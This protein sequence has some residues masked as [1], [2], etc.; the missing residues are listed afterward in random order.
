MSSVRSFKRGNQYLDKVRKL[1]FSN[2]VK[3]SYYL[4]NTYSLDTLTTVSEVSFML[5]THVGKLLEFEEMTIEVVNGPDSLTSRNNNNAATEAMNSALDEMLEYLKS[6][7]RKYQKIFKILLIVLVILNV[8]VYPLIFISQV[9]KIRQ[10]RYEIL[11]TLTTLPKTVISGISASL[12]K[13]KDGKEG[14]DSDSE[15]NRQEESIIKLF[16]SISDGSSKSSIEVSIL[17]CIIFI[18]ILSCLGYYTSINCFM[19]SSK[20]LVFNSHHINYL[21][22][23]V[24]YLFAIIARLFK[25]GLATA[26]RRLA[27]SIVSIDHEIE[28]I[29]ETTPLLVSYFQL[30]RIGGPGN[31]EKPFPQMEQAMNTAS[32]L[33]KCKDDIAPPKTVMESVHCM[34]AGQQLYISTSLIK[35][36]FAQMTSDPPIY[37]DPRDISLQQLFQIGPVELYQSFFAKAGNQILPMIRDEI[38]KEESKQ[39]NFAVTFLI[40]TFLFSLII[41]VFAKNEEKVLLFTLRLFLRCPPSSIIGNQRVMDLLSGK[42]NNSNEE[43]HS[44]HVTFSNEVCNKIDTVIVVCEE[45][46]GKIVQ[47]NAAFE[48]MFS[49]KKNQMEGKN[50][51]E[52]FTE[53]RFKGEDLEKVFSQDANLIYTKSD[54]ELVYLYFN[55]TTA[56]G[57]RIY[58]GTNQTMNV[59][60]EKLIEDEKKK[61]DAMLNSI[62][63]PILVQRVQS[64]EKNISFSVQSVT[65]L[66]LDIVEF[67]PWC[68]SHDCHYVMRML[69]ILF[70]EFDAITNSHKTMTKIKCIGDCYMA[71]G[72]IFDEVNQPAVHAREVVEFGT[73]VIKKILEI[74][75]NENESLRI[76]V[77][78]NTGGPIV[79]GVIGTEKPTFEILGPAINIAHEMEHHGV[80]MK[81][82]ISRPVYELIYGQQFDIKERGEIDVKGGKM[83]TYLVEP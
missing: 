44:K 29:N 23:A 59:M 49:M 22:G 3:F 26:S 55:T 31:A 80:P 7:N 30:I 50:I 79:A 58:F 34:T 9:R 16:S 25:V 74:D 5:A 36:Y 83:F 51:H 33:L 72:G 45:E 39:V 71:A 82:H 17:F 11:H 53:E 73:Q 35:K 61:S 41:V 28:L 42:Y 57:K 20:N 62:L 52:F 78:I 75:E 24:V 81:V 18:V 48:T 14:S 15:L 32:N 13:T 40:L 2:S 60:H 19:Q 37:P 47:V 1:L 10:N 46:T 54:N 68:S 65:V 21:Y 43:N 27:P 4:N 6:E 64:G 70:K 69:N 38:E 67:T 77:G 8:I 12:S 66:F 56:C 76:R 63:P